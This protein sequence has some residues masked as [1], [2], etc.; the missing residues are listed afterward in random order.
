MPTVPSEQLIKE[1]CPQSPYNLEQ[2][3][4]ESENLA[5]KK[6][7]IKKP[8]AIKAE[9]QS[10]ESKLGNRVTFQEPSKIDDNNNKT[11]TNMESP[12]QKCLEE[13]PPYKEHPCQQFQEAQKEQLNGIVK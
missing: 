12:S 9:V 3:C 4:P 2:T 8:S 1:L 5:A 13:L 6:S 11:L 10:K 7:I